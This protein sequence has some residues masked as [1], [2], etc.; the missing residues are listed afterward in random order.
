[1]K[2]SLSNYLSQERMERVLCL[3]E[4]ESTN[5]YLRGLTLR[6][7]ADGQVVVARRQSAGRGR[8]GKSFLSPEGGIYLSM[9]HCPA[10][11][12]EPGA[13]TAGAA[14]A[15]CRA[16]ERTCGVSPGIKWVNDLVLGGRKIC[17]ILAETVA[18][19][20]E[21]RVIIGVGLNVSTPAEAFGGELAAIAGSILSR[22][23][24]SADHAELAAAVIEELDG[25]LAALPERAAEK[26]EAYRSRCVTTGREV[27]V[28][29]GDRTET[30]FAESVDEDFSLVVRYADGRCE[31]VSFGE[32]S[33]RGENGEYV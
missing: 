21:T 5:T 22:T 15:V 17:G 10:A 19:E 16:L 20:G 4:T 25:M 11:G 7:A 29:R 30:A 12:F 23:G 2:T 31:K 14:V 1:M 24:V 8:S 6:G 18:V 28:R 32:V 26:L 3:E 9:L 13:M 33:I 27:L